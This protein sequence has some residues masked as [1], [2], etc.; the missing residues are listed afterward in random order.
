MRPLIVIILIILGLAAMKL[1]VWD[2][3][4]PS[5]GPASKPTTKRTA[6]PVDVYVAAEVA[7]DNTIYASGTIVPNEEVDLQSE[8]SGRLIELNIKEGSFVRKGQLIAKLS[9]DDLQAQMKRLQY[10]DQLASQIETRQKKLLNIDAISVEEYDLAVNKLNTLQADKEFLQVQI[11]KTSVRAPFSGRIGFKHIS[12]GAYITPS[13]IIANLVQTNP[14]KV[15][16]AIPEKYANEVAIGREIT[17]LIDG[18]DDRFLAKV[19]AI[20]PMVDEDLRTLKL[21]ARADN[22]LGLLRPG[23][24]VRVEVP[25]ESKHS[26]MVPTEAVMPILKGK[27]AYVKKEGKA[28]QVKVL[29]GL[30]TDRNIQILDGINVGDSVIVSALMSLKPNLPVT[31]RNSVAVNTNE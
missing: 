22:S 17:F 15:D 25:L 16:F 26:I 23:M 3:D 28:M 19:M 31:L 20:D 13:V 18:I 10:E 2:K 29:T 21:R 8:A 12:E 4:S 11:E 6:L 30:R 9:D 1:Y 7:T 27:I 14:V 24:F 5:G